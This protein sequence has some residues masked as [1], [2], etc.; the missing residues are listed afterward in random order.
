MVL[1]NSSSLKTCHSIAQRCV[2]LHRTETTVISLGSHFAKINGQ[3]KWC[4]QTVKNLLKKTTAESSC[5][6]A[7][8]LST[9]V[10]TTSA[11]F[12]PKHECHVDLS[13]RR[14]WSDEQ[15]DQHVLPLQPL[16]LGEVVHVSYNKHWVPGVF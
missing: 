9:K 5:C 16:Q 10:F 12:E 1:L 15:H 4:I 13:L 2:V 11:G 6:L 8:S 14:N 7:E 3:V